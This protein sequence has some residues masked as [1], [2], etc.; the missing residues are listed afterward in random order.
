MP[1]LVREAVCAGC[2]VGIG[3]SAPR[4]VALDQSGK[5]LQ[6]C[7]RSCYEG[8]LDQPMERKQGAGRK[9]KPGRPK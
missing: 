7:N 6:F 1:I 5:S 9:G 3:G 8:W 4:F 2:G